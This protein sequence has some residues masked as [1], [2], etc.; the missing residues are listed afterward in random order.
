M[1]IEFWYMK[2][3]CCGTVFALRSE[4][5][6]G[7]TISNQ[8]GEYVTSKNLTITYCDQFI[9]N[10]V[11]SLMGCFVRKKKKLAIVSQIIES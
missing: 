11:S 8:M 7:P 9:G 2:K 10:N 6:V 5:Y 1:S 4:V 3:Q